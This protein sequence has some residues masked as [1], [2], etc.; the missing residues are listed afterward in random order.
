MPRTPDVDGHITV[1]R[2]M[3]SAVGRMHRRG[4]HLEYATL[5]WNVAGVLIIAATTWRARSVALAGFGLDSLIEIFA[6]LVV[7]WRLAGLN[8]PEVVA[9]ALRRRER[10]AL[11]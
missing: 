9:L 8:A 1:V 3:T 7:L 10:R 2:T 4:V 6:S 5:M 11:R